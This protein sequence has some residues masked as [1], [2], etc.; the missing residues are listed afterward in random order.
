MGSTQWYTFYT[1]DYARD[2]AHLSM[3]EHG[4]YRLLLDYYYSSEKPLPND[5]KILYRICKAATK[6]EQKIV[7]KVVREFFVED[8]DFF[9]N[10]RV[11]KEIKKRKKKSKQ[12]S[13]AAKTKHSREKE[14]KKD[15]ANAGANAG[16][17]AVQTHM[18]TQ[19]RP[20]VQTH[21]QTQCLPQPQ[22]HTDLIKDN[23]ISNN[24]DTS[25][26]AQDA[27]KKEEDFDIKKIIFR[28]GLAY[29]TTRGVEEKNARKLLGKWRKDF[30]DALTA[31]ALDA[32]SRDAVS[33]PVSFIQTILTKRG[34]NDKST[35]KK[36]SKSSWNLPIRF[37]S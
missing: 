21:M 13:E 29:L 15:S 8:E 31:E 17:N 25:Y 4:C 30:G 36:E 5:M 32:A 1:G 7:Q 19:V 12:C 18:R 33:E 22:P 20:Q 27:P 2:T 34:K 6:N 9:T 3:I 26:R 35:T 11:N 24:S 23:K 28:D 16:A 10:E 14:R 37:D